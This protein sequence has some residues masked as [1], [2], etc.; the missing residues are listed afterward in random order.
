[1]TSA[2]SRAFS[3]CTPPQAQYHPHYPLVT[4]TAAV[5]TPSPTHYVYYSTTYYRPAT[6]MMF[7]PQYGTLR[8][9]SKQCNQCSRYYDDDG[10]QVL[11][12]DLT[13]YIPAWTVRNC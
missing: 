12:P 8:S 6:A 9:P 7:P 4:T 3:C 13:T 1:M 11:L 2:G 10:S 5:M